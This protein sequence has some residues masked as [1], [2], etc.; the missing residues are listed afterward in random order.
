MGLLHVGGELRLG[1]RL[2]LEHGLRVIRD[3]RGWTL[4]KISGI[5]E[6]GRNG[7][8]LGWC[9]ELL[10]IGTHHHG[11]VLL[12]NIAKV[13]WITAWLGSLQYLV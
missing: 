9:G 4:R 12:W 2:L 6:A 13:R 3:L 7:G 5:E 10:L 11:R 8:L 1:L